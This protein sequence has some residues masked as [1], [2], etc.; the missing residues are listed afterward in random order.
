MD[1]GFSFAAA[2]ER[3]LFPRETGIMCSN[4]RQLF[5]C[6]EQL[7]EQQYRTGRALFILDSCA[8]AQLFNVTSGA[9]LSG[10]AYLSGAGTALTGIIAALPTLMNTVQIFSSVVY[11]NCSG[12]KR[13]TVRFA[14]LQRLCLLMLLFVPTLM[15]P[16]KIAVILIAL[17]YSGAHFFGAFINTGANNWL[18]SLVKKDRLGRY[19]GLKDS[20]T[21]VAATGG[22]LLLSKMLDAYRSAGLEVT[23]FRTIGILCIGFCI[24]D[25]TCLSLIREPVNETQPEPLH[26][27]QAIQMPLMDRE[28]RRILIFFLLWGIGSNLAAPF[29]SIY[30][31]EHLGLSYFYIT[32]MNMVASVARI[33][34]A[35]LWGKAADTHSWRAVTFGSVFMLGAGYV[36]WGFLTK[37][38]AGFWLPVI[39]AACGAA[40]GGINIA[41]FRMQFS[42][43]PSGHRVSYVSF[44]S[45]MVGFV[46]FLSAMA[47]S[48]L[49][50]WT[51]GMKV[52]NTPVSNMQLVFVLSAL[53]TMVCAIYSCKIKEK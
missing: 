53:I 3:P 38:N 2:E 21:L 30:M 47:G 13:I 49:V 44:C 51:D 9:F 22:S 39:Q 27:R 29:F 41:T 18:M 25:I 26:I 48:A 17:L 23:G 1:R 7:T 45:T 33:V 28:Y 43:A 12:S 10:L 31:L 15:L 24:I 46:G 8:A 36:G 4:L 37:E 14:L 34:A 6:S 19:L 52:L 20:M 50:A 42:F 35:N 5:T 11:E 40:W 32:V 16:S